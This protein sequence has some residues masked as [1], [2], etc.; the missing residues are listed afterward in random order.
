MGKVSQHSQTYS[1][2]DFTLAAQISAIVCQDEACE[3]WDDIS[4]HRQAFSE[5]ARCCYFIHCAW[6]GQSCS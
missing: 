5:F 4:N 3:L 1:F 2:Y 6:Y